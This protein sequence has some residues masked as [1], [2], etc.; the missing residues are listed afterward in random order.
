MVGDHARSLGFQS[1][2]LV[3]TA[4]LVLHAKAGE[5]ES[6]RQ[7]FDQM[8]VKDVVSWNAMISGYSQAGLLSEAM[9]IF[10]NMRIVEGICA[11]EG[12]F[13]S[14]F[15]CCGDEGQVQNGEAL[16]ALVLITG[17][18]RNQLVLNSLLEMYVECSCL[19]IAVQLFDGM[20]LK[21]SVSWSTMIGGYV[22]N[23]QPS[24]ALKT[25]YLMLFNT[26]I[27]PT[28]PILLNSLLAC[29][30][31][32]DWETGKWIQKKFLSNN[33]DEMASDASLIT[34][35]IYMHARCRKM[36]IAFEFLE[37]DARMKGDVIAWN[38]AIKACA[39]VGD[40]RHVFELSLKM[41]RRGI[42]LD[43]ATFLMLLSIISTIP[44]SIKGAETHALV[45]KLG[46][47]SERSIAN[48]LIDMYAHFGNLES[49]Y[50]IF[51]GMQEKDV[52][53]WSLIIGAYAWNGNAE[54]AFDLFADMREKEVRPN[55]FTFLALLSACSHVG[56][57]EKGRE[58]FA[59]MERYG[60]NP[61]IEHLTC[62]ID[63]FCRAGL[64]VD[65]HHLLKDVKLGAST[66][67]I[68]WG[69]LLSACRVH[70][71]LVI[72]E[73]AAT[74]LFLLEPGNAANYLMLADIY[75]L[76]GK[77]ENSNAVFRLLKEKGI[78][79]R[80]GCSWFDAG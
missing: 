35:L 37:I 66:S 19:E 40:F 27:L 65:A 18:D 57:V 76:L 51:K 14:L 49:S 10:R 25:L 70:G 3:A 31:L 73:A 42:L 78:E 80:P 69:T 53:S 36:E 46:F 15:S 33:D 2:I 54:G 21:D 63:L 74:H 64:L 56:L 12:S 55:Q 43:R 52:V 67:S 8:S 48:S 39:E 30:S 22:K 4:L 17:F 58:L 20:V 11:T 50:S 75:I 7:V 47:E 5:L 60:L 61:G 16:H 23:D 29:A 1:D 38:T 9:E 68:L 71:N 45:V 28:R 6:A 72:G 13:V 34:T 44:L 62:L 79:K 32:G 41:Q 24:K 26:C 59:S 77:M